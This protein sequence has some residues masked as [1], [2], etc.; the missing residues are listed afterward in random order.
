MKLDTIDIREFSQQ[1]EY[2][3]PRRESIEGETLLVKGDNRSGKT[4]TFNAL[5]YI[6]VGETINVS[7]GRGSELEVE[8][9][10]GSRFYRGLPTMS[11]ETGGE[12]FTANEARERLREDTGPRK[13]LEIHFLHSHIEKLP[14]ERMSKSNLLDIIRSVTEPE[15]QSLLQYHTDAVDFLEWEISVANDRLRKF[16]ETID[17]VQKKVQSFERQ[18]EQAEKIVLMGE[19]GQLAEIQRILSEHQELDNELQRL[20]ER[21]DGIRKQLSQKRNRRDQLR[22]YEKEVDELIAEAVNDFVCPACET[23]V[24]SQI[25]EERLDRNKCP[26]CD[27]RTSISDL[28][29]ELKQKQEDS[30]GVADEIQEEIDELEKER[31][32]VQNEISRIKAELPSLEELDADAKRR[33]NRHDGD[34]QAVIA[35]AKEELDDVRTKLDSRSDE[36]EEL[37]DEAEVKEECV[38]RLKDAKEFASTQA[39]ELRTESHGKSVISFAEEWTKSFEAVA[40]SMSQE[41]GV[42]KKG[43][44]F[45]PGTPSNRP[46]GGEHLSDSE[47]QL[48]NLSFAITL[49]KFIDEKV[50]TLDTIVLDEPF[51]HLDDTC[52]EQVLDFILAD[53]ERQ[54]V[55]TSSN[56][57]VWDVVPESQVL[58]LNRSSIQSEL[59]E[60]Y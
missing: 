23:S 29:N 37:E 21:K 33:L 46:Y 12:E 25:A 52:T 20:F 30:E 34:V 55:F 44:V 58:K 27:R 13:L 10:D 38:E 6:L 9:T 11:Y 43:E 26:F 49:N 39:K 60:F 54:Y 42:S 22:T 35:E 24:P 41:I 50:A 15:Q 19:S 17:D 7:P 31:E 1:D 56:R 53:K 57:D 59:T 28:Q 36:L 14:L 48:L 8:F 40:P 4:L 32:E 2:N 45:L 3:A 51:N 47:R 5:R 18:E 16:E